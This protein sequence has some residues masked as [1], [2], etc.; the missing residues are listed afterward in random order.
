MY[1]ASE[2]ESLSAMSDSLGPHGLYSPQNSPGQNTGAGCRFLL[3]GIFLTQ[4][5]NPGLLNRRQ[6]LNHLSHQGSPYKASR[7]VK[8]Q[9]SQITFIHSK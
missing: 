1:K 8:R 6:I 4:G 7:R 2:R 9:S 3:Q 5:S